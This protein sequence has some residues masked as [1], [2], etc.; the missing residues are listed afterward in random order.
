MFV[1]FVALCYYEYFSEEVRKLK[2]TLGI[3]TGDKNH[4]IKQT[5]DEERRLKSWICN[6]P[7]YLQL[8]W[9]DTIEQFWQGA[10]ISECVSSGSLVI[11]ICVPV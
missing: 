1:Q 11:I 10:G 8:Q 3:E 7:L 6:T 4:D 2:A 9:F 5:L